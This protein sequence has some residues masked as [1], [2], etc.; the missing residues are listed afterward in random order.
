MLERDLRVGSRPDAQDCHRLIAAARAHLTN[1]N[2]ERDGDRDGASNP[3]GA[4]AAPLDGTRNSVRGSSVAGQLK[5]GSNER[6]RSN[7]AHPG[8]AVRGNLDPIASIKEAAR[9]K[10]RAEHGPAA[11]IPL[12]DAQAAQALAAPANTNGERDADRAISDGELGAGPG[13]VS[14]GSGVGDIPV[15]APAITEGEEDD[16]AWIRRE[17]IELCEATENSQSKVVSTGYPDMTGAYARGRVHEAK[18]IRRALCAVIEE[19]GFARDLRASGGIFPA[20]IAAGEDVVVP[21]TG[22]TKLDLPAE[23]IVSGASAANL[24]TV[25]VIGFDGNG[26]FFFSSNKADGGEVL[27]L[28]ELARKKLMEIGDQ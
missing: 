24:E 10:L 9:E 26:D 21:F 16:L 11:E 27:W 14:A 19:R 20:P 15:A 2:G 4:V 17:I 13:G 8:A 25:V 1:T 7:L 12:E 28:M 6:D 5:D 22:I 23:R 18:G 3:G